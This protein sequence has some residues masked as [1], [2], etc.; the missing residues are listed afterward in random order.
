MTLWSISSDRLGERKYHVALAALVAACGWGLSYTS[1]SPL[2]FLVGLC[3]AQ[4]G[5]MSM[6]PTFWALPTAFLS[7]AAA[8]AGI[9]LINSVGNIGGAF[10]PT[11]VGQGGPGVVAAIMF[12][13]FAL[14]LCV[15]QERATGSNGVK[16][17]ARA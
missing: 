17:D 2:V 10:A 14:A 12:A 15:R 11:I 5:M 8:A 1:T 13:G 16:G 3:L 7:G 4:M 6:L 9:A